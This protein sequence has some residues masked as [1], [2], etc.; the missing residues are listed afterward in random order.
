M[1]Q[2]SSSEGLCAPSPWASTWQMGAEFPRD[3]NMCSAITQHTLWKHSLYRIVLLYLYIYAYVYLPI[4]CSFHVIGKLL[5]GQGNEVSSRLHYQLFFWLKTDNFFTL[6]KNSQGLNR[7]SELVSKPYMS[8][9]WHQISSCVFKKLTIPLY[10][11]CYL[12]SIHYFT[13]LY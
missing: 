10:C 2:Q 3:G 7:R 6:Q 13:F 5:S 4:L 11:L 1:H 12:D 8:Q 9:Y